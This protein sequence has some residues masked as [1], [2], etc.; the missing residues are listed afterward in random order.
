MA[1]RGCLR[2]A[3]SSRRRAA[4]AAA[5]G[6]RMGDQHHAAWQEEALATAQRCGMRALAGRLEQA[7]EWHVPGPR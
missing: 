5:L 3:G 6:R 1:G 2:P 4:D 7:G